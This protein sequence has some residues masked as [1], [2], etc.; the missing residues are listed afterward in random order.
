MVQLAALDNVSN[1]PAVREAQSRILALPHTGMAATIDIGDVKDV[2][3]HHKEPPG[4]RLAK[5]ALAQTYGRKV[6]FSGP[7]YVSAQP[8]GGA[9][10]LTFSHAAGLTA[11]EGPP[12]TFQV[13]GSDHVFVDADAARAGNSVV[14]RSEK[15]T[16]PVAVRYAWANYPDGANLYN[17]DGLP[18]AP[19]RTGDWDALSAIAVGFSG[20]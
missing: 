15:V 20:K 18:T 6:E 12:K 1:N 19:F 17:S 2:H 3:P 4:E 9:V 7:V 10:R 11:K 5:I 8:A 14:V 13:A 16:D